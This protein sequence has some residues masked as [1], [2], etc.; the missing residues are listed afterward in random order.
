[1]SAVEQKFKRDIDSLAKIFEFIDQFSAQELV[2]DDSQR[3]FDLA[4]DELF[5]NT[6]KYHPSNPHDVSIELKTEN[7]SMYLILTDF[8]VDSF[9]VT[10]KADPELSGSLEDRTPGGLG[11]YLTKRVVDEVQYQ[12][13]NRTSIIT[14]RKSFRRKN[15]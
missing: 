2:D 1:M 4:V 8:E 10:K 15:V 13:H 5:T 9:D 3:A 12:Y 7:Q 14:L 11:I 6:V